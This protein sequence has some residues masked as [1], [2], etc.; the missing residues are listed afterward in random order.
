MSTT[1]LTPKQL[2]L[3]E[4]IAVSQYQSEWN[5]VGYAIWTWDAVDGLPKKSAGGVVSQAA[6]AGLIT[7]FIEPNPEDNSVALTEKGWLALLAEY[8]VEHTDDEKAVHNAFHNAFTARQKAADEAEAAAVEAELAKPAPAPSLAAAPKASAVAGHKCCPKCGTTGP[9]EATFGY[10]NTK[11]TRKD[12]TV[13]EKLR[14]QS[15]CRA[16]RSSKK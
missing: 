3:L 15:Y 13:V 11:H 16:C 10:R 14:V 6:K 8:G 2:T 12:G 4:G 1:T 5:P 9:I 7:S